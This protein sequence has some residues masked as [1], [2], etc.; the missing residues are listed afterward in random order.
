MATTAPLRRLMAALTAVLIAVTACGCSGSQEPEPTASATRTTGK[1]ALFTPN[2]GFTLAQDVPLNTW[3]R[4]ASTLEDDLVSQGFDKD[5]IATHTS[6]DL[7]AQSQAV[8]DYVVDHVDADERD[9]QYADPQGASQSTT[10]VVAPAI[11]SN[12]VTRYYGDYVT[13]PSGTA[14][15]D[16]AAAVTRLANALKLAKKGGMHVVMVGNGIDGFTPDATVTLATAADIGAMEARQLVGKLRLDAASNANPKYV[17]VLLPVAKDN[18]QAERFAQEA[19]KGVWQVLGPYFRSGKAISPSLRLS[20][21]SGEDDWRD[22][23]FTADSSG[24]V[25]KELRERLDAKGS[26][27]KRTRIDGIVAMNDFAAAAVCQELT[28]L[29]YTGSA[30]DINPSITIGDVVGN[31]TGKQDLTRRQVPDP[32]KAPTGDADRSEEA[33]DDS[34]WPIVTGFGAYISNMPDIVNGKQ[35]MTGLVNPREGALDISQLCRYYNQGLDTKE[36]DFLKDGAVAP[37]LEAVSA[38]N[39]KAALIDPG[40]I[41]LADAGL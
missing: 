22:V 2:D 13:V 24:D 26:D 35:W 3:H 8:Q 40:Y 41:T 12:G 27:D 31:M 23:A 1:V 14:D 19:F 20:S 30:A 15:S 25:A 5:D 36:L 33:T 17:E 29:K 18:D 37:Q 10:L 4:L 11:A 16:D 9:E 32:T 38:G 39:L 28:D 34:Q 6:G 7:A 21:S